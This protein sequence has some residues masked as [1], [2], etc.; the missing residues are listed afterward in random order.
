MIKFLLE[1]LLLEKKLLEIKKKEEREGLK[2]LLKDYC[3]KII[4][5]GLLFKDYC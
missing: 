1:K 4:V 3:Q 5:K 2:E